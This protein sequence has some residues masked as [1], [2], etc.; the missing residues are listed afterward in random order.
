MQNTVQTLQ[1][2]GDIL[3]FASKKPTFAWI[4]TLNIYENLP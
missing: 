4:V 1:M 2:Y 3:R